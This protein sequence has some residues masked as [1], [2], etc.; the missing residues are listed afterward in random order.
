M[1][2]APDR[3]APRDAAGIADHLQKCWD[4]RMQ[5]TIVA[6]LAHGRPGLDPLAREAVE[7][8]AKAEAKT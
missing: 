7:R 1:M 8:L 4:P 6:H 3:S 5:S 2:R